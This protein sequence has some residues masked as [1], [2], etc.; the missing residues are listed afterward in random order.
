M[1]AHT[2]QTAEVGLDRLASRVLENAPVVILVLDL[3]GEVL[4]VNP[5]LE[6]LSGWALEE[7]RGKD[8]FDTFL[9]E[10]DRGRVREVFD[11]SSRGE[12]VR[13]Y[14]NPVLTRAGE[15][16]FVEWS[17]VFLRDEAGVPEAVLAIGQDVTERYAAERALRANEERLRA[18]IESTPAGVAMLDRDLRYIACS[19]RFRSDYRLGDEDLVGKSHL[20]F[21]P[22]LPER[23]REVL[24]QGLAGVAAHCDADRFERAD[25]SVHDLRWAIEPW[26]DASGEIGGVVVFTEDIGERRR[27]ER[28]ERDEETKAARLLRTA[29]DGMPSF[30]A[31]YDLD[32]RIVEANRTPLAAIGVSREEVLGRRFE[33]TPWLGH[34]EGEKAKFR[35]AL[36]RVK[37]G[38]V[39]NETFR[40]YVG[41]PEPAEFEA[42]FAPLFD[43]HGRI[44]R[45]IGSGIDVTERKRAEAEAQRSAALLR[46]VVTGAPVVMFALDREGVFKLSEGRALEKLG[47]RPGQ[48]VGASS[49]EVYGAIPGYAEAF[50]RALAGEQVTLTGEVGPTAFEAAYAPSYDAEGR[51][52]GVVGVGL[53]VTERVRAERALRESEERLRVALEASG[54]ATVELDLA[55]EILRFGPDYARMLG[56]EPHELIIQGRDAFSETIHPEDREAAWSAFADHVDGRAPTFDAEVRFRT[57]SGGWKWFR[58]IGRTIERDRDGRPLRLIGTLRGH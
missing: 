38:E 29:I 52:D 4:H 6:R 45:V 23:W 9:P 31:V 57:K 33:E 16:R 49:L 21:F 24:R 41:R 11:R 1:T 47:V 48:L 55:A 35:A 51:V 2:T 42:T 8:W 27:L 10:R 46:T 20:D 30:I 53:D 37:V 26:R 18:I 19:R 50:R 12:H 13:G 28:Q 44:D 58:A 32:G 39:V 36:A 40:V 7:V 15:E 3:D 43:E 14:V 34:S 22:D 54:Q 5:F 17:D 25:G 56:Y